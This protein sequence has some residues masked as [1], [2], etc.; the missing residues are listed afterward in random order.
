MPKKTMVYTALFYSA[1]IIVL[2]T[3]G[4][5]IFR[6][7]G[8]RSSHEY[9]SIAHRQ[10]ESNPG[11]DYTTPEQEHSAPSMS[12]VRDT[13]V[14]E[15]QTRTDA[16][17]IIENES[18]DTSVPFPPFTSLDRLEAAFRAEV[19]GDVDVAL[20]EYRRIAETSTGS[21]QIGAINRYS[22]AARRK[23]GMT[24]GLEKEFY[25][26]KEKANKEDFEWI[27][28]SIFNNN[29]DPRECYRAVLQNAQTPF[30]SYA[31]VKL[32]FYPDPSE[33]ADEGVFHSR[34]MKALQR[35][36]TDNPN[37]PYV[38][39][40]KA[41]IA[42]CMNRQG[43]KEEAIAVY[44]RLLHE[45]RGDPL[46]CAGCIENLFL[47][48]EIDDKDLGRKAGLMREFYGVAGDGYYVQADLD[49]QALAREIVAEATRYSSP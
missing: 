10:G 44:R 20:Q 24:D 35:F 8:N 25:S 18:A 28:L 5:Y 29:I 37:D 23:Y 19:H 32:A 21:E 47:L 40:A 13:V 17:S 41:R 16:K 1:C 43:R 42:S 27:F 36:I 14:S 26:L 38:P 9:G 31:Q 2:V 33:R 45:W 3:F 34:A 7:P 22:F 12:S 49:V 39:H 46:V 30:A 48:E 4:F 6:H 15:M 11:G